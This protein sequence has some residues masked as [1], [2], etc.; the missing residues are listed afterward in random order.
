M[1]QSYSWEFL[2]RRYERVTTL[3]PSVVF[4]ANVNLV[5]VQSDDQ[6]L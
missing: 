5:E 3:V 1:R 4:T 6:Q 2:T